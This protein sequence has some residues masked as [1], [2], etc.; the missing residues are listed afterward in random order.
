[1]VA[2]AAVRL[3]IASFKAASRRLRMSNRICG[4]RLSDVV[5]GKARTLAPAKIMETA[6]GHRPFPDLLPQV[7]RS[8]RA[9]GAPPPTDE[10]LGLY[11]RGGDETLHP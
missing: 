9:N 2:G 6:E 11:R 3:A 10:S 4:D 1:M 5:I 7:G 8:I